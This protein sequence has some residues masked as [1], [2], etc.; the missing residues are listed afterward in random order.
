LGIGA[1]TAIFSVVRAVLLRTLPYPE[2]AQLVVVR[3]H[4]P[5]SGQM[6]IA[7]P[8]FLDWREQV[9]SLRTPAGYRLTR[10]NVSGAREPELLRAPEISPPFLSL[11]DVRPARGRDLQP[12]DDR[13]G[14][15]R[16]VLLSDELWKARFGSDP[17]IVGRPV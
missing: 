6:G 3:E 12:S 2:P 15:E 9:Q 8:N 4:H 14:A 7:W 11:L 13:P 5:G 17:A 16:T 10:W 1:N